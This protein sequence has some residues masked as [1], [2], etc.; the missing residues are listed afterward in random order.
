MKKLR[1]MMAFSALWAVSAVFN[2]H[3]EEAKIDPVAN[4]KQVAIEL[5]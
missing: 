1:M 2:C 3:A 4:E 5:K